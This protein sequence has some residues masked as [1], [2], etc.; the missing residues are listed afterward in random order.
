MRRWV[1]III[2]VSASGIDAAEGVDYLEQVKPILAERCVSC[3]GAL[4]QRGGLRLDA[5]RLI[6]RGG[7][8][9]VALEAGHPAG[10]LLIEKVTATDPEER[11]PPEGDPLRA[12]QIEILAAWIRAGAAIPS[13]EPIPADPREHWSFAVP[14][15]V[16]LPPVHADW[17][18]QPLDRFVLHQQRQRGLD[19]A[20]VA[21]RGILLRRVYL[22][23][24]G[25]PPTRDQ[26][27]GF[28]ADDSPAA[29]DR[30]VDGLLASPD[31]GLRWAR[32][33]MDVW[34]YSDHSGY[35]MGQNNDIRDGRA[36]IWRWRDWIIESLNEDKGY[37]RMVVEMLAGDEIAPSDTKALRAT[38]FLARNWYKFNRNVWLDNIVEHASKAFLG[39]TVNCARCHDHKYD[40]LAQTEYFQLRAIF[41][42]HEVRD[43]PYATGTDPLV[44][45]FDAYAKRPTYLFEQGDER[46]P[47]KGQTL[48]PQVPA[49]FGE[50]LRVEPVSLP[51]VAYYPALRSEAQDAARNAA[52]A[53]VRKAIEGV[54]SAEQR[55]AAARQRLARF[56]EK[57]PEKRRP[58]EVRD[59]T[60]F[61]EETFAELAAERWQV[62]RGDWKIVE[63][64]L[65][66]GDGASE[67]RRLVS[68]IS[69]PRDFRAQLTM[70][71]NGGAV[72][73][74]VGFGF[75]VHG[76]AMHAVYLSAYP[77]ASKVQVTLQNGE[78][79]WSY[80]QQGMAAFPVELGRDYRLE[81]RVRDR[82]LNVLVD[83]QLVVAYLLPPNRAA[84]QVALWTFSATGSFDDVRVTALTDQHIVRQPTASGV[85]PAVETESGLRREV[86]EAEDGSVIAKLSETSARA[87]QA[88]LLLRQQ[89]E[90]TKYGLEPGDQADRATA[91][92]RAEVAA[93]LASQIE[94]EARA[95]Q[96]VA[97]L[98]Q[99]QNGSKGKVGAKLAQA[100][101]TLAAA[102]KT[103]AET[104]KRLGFES[105]EYQPLGALHP[106]T[107]TGRRLAWARW[108]TGD[109]N[110]LTAR[111]A[112]NQIWLRHFGEPLVERMFDF[113]L[114]SPA[115]LHQAL[116]D[117]LA[118]GFRR[119]WSMKRLHGRIVT[120]GVYRLASAASAGGVGN[121]ERDPDNQLLWRAHVRRMDAEVV[122]DSLLRV[123]GSLDKAVGGPPIVHTL[124]QTVPR[125]SIFF[126]QDKERQMVF[127]SL[128]DGAKVN[129]CYRRVPTV[130]PQQALAMYNS[131]LASEQ[132]TRLAEQVDASVAADV[133]TALF[134]TI[135][136]RRATSQELRECVEYLEEFVDSRRGRQQLA[137]VLLNHN[138]FL[139]VR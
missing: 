30:A 120:S 118:V 76:R 64:R 113:G 77:G 1:L 109:S 9:G 48:Q 87:E 2:A 3:H 50:P 73:R 136:S 95:R 82:L 112:V 38:G 45:V 46:R 66:Q 18:R 5:A 104:R 11:M 122:R 74:S 80:P 57:P 124:G 20:P 92:S 47:D 36:H 108:I 61:L 63:G 43:E 94:Q 13:D 32:H 14:S 75:D 69:H 53:K 10:S 79:V 107:S 59:G 137:L 37:D 33:W 60:L 97:H 81:L 27:V 89:A 90:R 98:Q 72:Y 111:V 70:R 25:L 52:Q 99:S 4:A 58:Q 91:A 100:E 139:S 84:G 8:S 128:F 102:S 101:K 24:I 39:L 71:V 6:L 19:V 51:T 26:L 29:L 68:R 40:P 103:V 15:E 135:L 12:E 116:L 96:Q 41:E 121:H 130:A 35:L 23:L 119:D 44:R 106:T 34:R 78:G 22:D 7:D 134:E 129:E 110:P 93:L 115:P 88:S 31:Y 54:V 28:L 21:E 132:A 133:V 62:E 67:Q 138:D 85:V 127:L 125:R 131:R 17:V 117:W 83:Q 16:S 126:R 114:R 86:G 105:R 55:V 65:R 123:G 49:V 42:A 56:L